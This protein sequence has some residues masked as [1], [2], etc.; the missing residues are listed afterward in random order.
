MRRECECVKK[1]YVGILVIWL[2]GRGGGE[3]DDYWETREK[4]T[5]EN[6]H[7]NW[8]NALD[9]WDEI[10]ASVCCNSAQSYISNIG[11]DLSVNTLQYSL[12]WTK[13]MLVSIC[14]KFLVLFLLYSDTYCS[15]WSK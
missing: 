11:N 8:T 13:Q 3:N 15:G 12:K 2:E 5:I 4:E 7:G 9:T 10:N 6:R 1:S 14:S